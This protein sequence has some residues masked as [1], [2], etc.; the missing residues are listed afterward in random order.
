MIKRK[1][2]EQIIRS[3]LERLPNI[4]RNH[5]LFENE[6]SS[7]NLTNIGAFVYKDASFIKGVALYDV[8][9]LKKKIQELSDTNTL[10]MPF[11]NDIILN[12]VMRGIIE[13]QSPNDPCNQAWYVAYIA[14]P[15]YGDTLYKLA[16]GMTPTYRLTSDRD[17]VKIGARKRWRK[18]YAAGNRDMMR[19]DDTYHEHPRGDD[20][21]TEDESDDC[22]V[23][24]SAAD[25]AGS[26]AID[27]DPDEP[28]D[29]LNYAYETLESDLILFQ[30]LKNVSDQ[31]ISEIVKI[32]GFNEEIG[33][34]GLEYIF[35]HNKPAFFRKHYRI[36][37]R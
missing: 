37:S 9:I 19:F 13:I 27:P 16:F 3:T 25:A 2:I 8:E 28:I 22:R 12:D 31:A 20:S 33:I 5:S 23:H 29:Q 32:K 11:L 21:H 35:R 24:I 15:G 4:K 6:G 36:D 17:T 7:D 34:K 18:I 30:E 14:G 10:I 1:L 26:Y